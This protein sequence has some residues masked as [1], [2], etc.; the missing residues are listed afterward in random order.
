[1]FDGY[2]PDYWQSPPQDPVYSGF[3]GGFFCGALAG[4][5]LATA[6][7]TCMA[8]GLYTSLF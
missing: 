7:F 8:V 5:M 2:L 3:W 6:W 4:A 1:M